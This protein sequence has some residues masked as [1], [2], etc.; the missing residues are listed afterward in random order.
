M[1]N[2]SESTPKFNFPRLDLSQP[3]PPWPDRW[4]RWTLDAEQLVL[5]HEEKYF[6]SLN[7]LSSASPMLDMIV[8]VRNKGFMTT[9]DVGDLVAAL[10]DIFHIQSSLVPFGRDRRI[11]DVPAFL[12]ERIAAR[13]RQD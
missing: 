6:V 5:R 11:E 1:E 7:R 4:G 3:I 2:E 9:T 13:T 12:R 8:Q 10:D